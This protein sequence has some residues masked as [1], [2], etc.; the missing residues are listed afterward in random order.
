MTIKSSTC[1][2]EKIKWNDENP[3]TSK[4]DEKGG[5]GDKEQEGEMENKY[6]GVDSNPTISIIILNKI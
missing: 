2:T 3:M 4:E 5:R 1:K 6:H